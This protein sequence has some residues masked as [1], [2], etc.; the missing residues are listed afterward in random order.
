MKSYI[1]VLALAATALSQTTTLK[2]FDAG[3][4]ALPL[5]DV[6]AS[7]VGVNALETTLALNCAPNATA[8]VCPLETPFTLTYGPST[9]TLNAAYTTKISGVQAKLSLVEGCD[10]VSS[11]QGA[12]CSL[13]MV[14][15]VSL[16]GTSTSRKT[17]TTTSYRS[18]DITYRDLAVTAGV[19]KLTAPEATQTPEGGAAPGAVGN[20][21][22]IGGLAAA[23]VAAAAMFV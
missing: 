1:T 14:I 11:T 2:V 18:E 10:I 6:A 9:A 16:R 5:T 7:V 15:G 17:S 22:G 20:G 8:S 23:A 3:E 21:K 13:S 19:S 12:S 4:S